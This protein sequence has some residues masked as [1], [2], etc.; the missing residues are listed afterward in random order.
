M[1]QHVFLFLFPV[2]VTRRVGLVSSCFLVCVCVCVCAAGTGVSLAL[3]S[4]CARQRCPADIQ[5]FEITRVTSA[6]EYY[7]EGINKTHVPEALHFHG[8]S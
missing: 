8:L 7:L 3:G 1:L 6:N 5:P 2:G 4:A